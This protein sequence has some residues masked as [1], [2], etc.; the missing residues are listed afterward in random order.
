[1][2]AFYAES[3]YTLNR[4]RA[5]DAFVALLSD[6]RQGRVWLIEDGAAI[7]GYV[8]ATFSFGMEYGG[9]VAWIDDLYVRPAHRGRGL[10]TS[11]LAAVRDS[12]A[13]LGCSALA[14]QVGSDNQPA[15]AA[16]RRTGLRMTE[17]RVMTLELR[18]P[19]HEPGDPPV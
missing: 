1:M 18:P 12:C 7:A 11:A 5:R 4:S 6:P 13:A 14:V 16:Y 15:L 10:A 17:R 2:A 19:T 8:V 9:T 3:D